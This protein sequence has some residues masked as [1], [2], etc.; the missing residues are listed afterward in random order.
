MSSAGSFGEVSAVS[1]M[2]PAEK[3]SWRMK[4]ERHVP[5]SST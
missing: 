4:N 1:T 2:L 5:F 3:A